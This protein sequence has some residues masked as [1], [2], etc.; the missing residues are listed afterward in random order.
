[1]LEGSKWIE[2]RDGSLEDQKL[3]KLV[4]SILDDWDPMTLST[5]IDDEYEVEAGKVAYLIKTTSSIDL[6]TLSKGIEDVL[7]AEF[8]KEILNYDEIDECPIIAQK[9]LDLL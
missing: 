1:M 9:I 4:L 2:M 8:G 7:V 5:G 6:D 3:F